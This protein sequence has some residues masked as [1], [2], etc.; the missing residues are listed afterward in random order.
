[1]ICVYSKTILLLCTD[2][3]YTI[4]LLWSPAVNFVFP[5]TISLLKYE[6]RGT[7][8]DFPDQIQLYLWILTRKK[9]YGKQNQ[10]TSPFPLHVGYACMLYD[11]GYLK[12]SRIWGFLGGL[13]CG[14]HYSHL[15]N[16][17]IVNNLY[18]IVFVT[19]IME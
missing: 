17:V 2:N 13:L 9:T 15:L 5:T 4:G 16:N 6:K 18:M 1:M 3:N 8:K 7:Q 14:N 11:Y 12:F 10:K 19:D